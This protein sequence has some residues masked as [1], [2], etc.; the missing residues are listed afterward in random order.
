MATSNLKIV[1]GV[2]A[3]N[4]AEILPRE[5]NDREGNEM[6]V[7]VCGCVCVY[8]RIGTYSMIAL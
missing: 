1:G 8:S 3:V 2:Q 4:I 5:S 6:C 7:W